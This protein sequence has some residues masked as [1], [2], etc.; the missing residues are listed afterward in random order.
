M[1]RPAAVKAVLRESSAWTERH[2]ICESW[3]EE[4][5]EAVRV[6]AKLS[7]RHPEEAIVRILD[8]V[9]EHRRDKWA[10]HCVWMALWLREQP[11][12]TDW[13]RFAIVARALVEGRNLEEISLMIAIAIRTVS[14]AMH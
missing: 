1:S 8:D 10:E 2:P 13:R 6:I 3:F 4:G 12:D 14:A 7:A 11:D 5:T 9:L